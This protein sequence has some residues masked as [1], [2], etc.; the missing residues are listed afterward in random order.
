[1]AVPCIGHNSAAGEVKELIQV[2]VRKGDRVYVLDVAH[3]FSW[4]ENLMVSTLSLASCRVPKVACFCIV[5]YYV[6]IEILGVLVPV[7]SNYFVF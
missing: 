2:K 3:S 1:M 4:L 7:I 5:L 6:H